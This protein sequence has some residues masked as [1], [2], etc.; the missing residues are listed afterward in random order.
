MDLGKRVY[1]ANVRNA[2]EFVE[3]LGINDRRNLDI[4]C[5]KCDR[6]AS[7][8]CCGDCFFKFS[9]EYL[10]PAYGYSAS[11]SSAFTK[12]DYSRMGFLPIYSINFNSISS[13]RFWDD[14]VKMEDF[15][16]QL[17]REKDLKCRIME[18]KDTYQHR[19]TVFFSNNQFLFSPDNWFVRFDLGDEPSELIKRYMKLTLWKKFTHG[20]DLENGNV[21]F[22]SDW[23]GRKKNRENKYVSFPHW[24]LFNF[25][26]DIWKVREL[27]KEEIKPGIGVLHKVVLRNTTKNDFFWN[28]EK[29]GNWEDIVDKT[30]WEEQHVC[31]KCKTVLFGTNN[32]DVRNRDIAVFT[33]GSLAEKL[34]KMK[35]GSTFTG[36]IFSMRRDQRDFS[37]NE[38]GEFY[39]LSSVMQVFDN[40][41]D[42]NVY[43]VFEDVMSKESDAGT[44]H[45]MIGRKEME[46]IM[47]NKRVRKGIDDLL[48]LAFP[49]LFSHNDMVY[50]LHPSFLVLFWHFREE[51]GFDYVDRIVGKERYRENSERLGLFVSV[52]SEDILDKRIDD[53]CASDGLRF[54]FGRNTG[55][56]DMER[57]R[58]LVKETFLC[59]KISRYRNFLNN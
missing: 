55:D 35:N 39:W 17:K 19:D 46:G 7:D 49:V 59:I 20:A 25:S 12:P 53:R 18:E 31:K 34:H 2:A 5:M 22:V 36:M 16:N 4:K 44:F 33:N 24:R 11:L 43:R 30:G 23:T 6:R 51:F 52:L 14:N 3:T 37:G 50:F 58:N 57:V 29:C 38:M 42:E 28:C 21:C 40:R 10:A 8:K 45:G 47:K 54:I 26:K 56:V 41:D 9:F 32:R 48:E 1:S 27:P 13:L 15:L